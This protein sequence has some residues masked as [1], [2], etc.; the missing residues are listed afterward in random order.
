VVFDQKYHLCTKNE[1]HEIKLNKIVFSSRNPD[2]T[3]SAI[4]NLVTNY[5]NFQNNATQN[6]LD[7]I[8]AVTVVLTNT[9]TKNNQMKS[10]DIIKYSS[11]RMCAMVYLSR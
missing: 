11:S 1:L 6:A 3:T 9:S 2:G 4:I 8:G 5:V 7:K 10:I